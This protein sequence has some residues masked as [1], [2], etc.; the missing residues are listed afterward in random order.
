M[1]REE[2]LNL[3]KQVL[4]CLNID[5]KIREGFETL[6]PELRES[7][8]E[9][10]RKGL[11]EVVSDIAGG[12]PFEEHRITKKEALA[13]LERQKEQKPA[14]WSKD[15]KVLDYLIEF[16]YRSDEDIFPERGGVSKL[17]ILT[18]LEKMKEQKLIKCIDF[19]NEF[20]NQVSHL[21]ASVLNGEYEYNEG[22]VKYAAQSLLGHAKKEQKPKIY[23]PKFRNGDKIKLKGSNLNLTITNIEGSRYY[24]KGWSLD[25]VSADE[26]YELVEQKPI[27]WS[28]EDEKMCTI[29]SSVIKSNI[30]DTSLSNYIDRENLFKLKNWFE[31]R[32]K[33][34]RPK[35]HWKPSEEQMK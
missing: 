34:L 17:D 8:D 35:P 26:S 24:G 6:I 15:E 9:R 20:E 25:I 11:I 16:I 3:V 33:F 1:K 13:Y 5:E 4:P 28:E 18:Y 7:D 29:M 12:W 2:A 32:L 23:I 10:I 19:D 14:E 31:N 30:G 27:E 22:F 21:L